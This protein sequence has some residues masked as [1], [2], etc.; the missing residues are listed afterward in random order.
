MMSWTLEILEST[1]ARTRPFMRTHV[2]SAL[3]VTNG[4]N[5]RIS[6]PRPKDFAL[7]KATVTQDEIL[8]EGEFVSPEK[9]METQINGGSG[10]H[11]CTEGKARLG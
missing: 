3:Y 11:W 6:L 8:I 4:V 2:A 10:K 9:N 5:Y 1:L 7:T